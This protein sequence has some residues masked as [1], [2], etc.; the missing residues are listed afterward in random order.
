VKYGSNVQFQLSERAT[1]VG[2]VALKTTGRQVGKTCK[3]QTTSN[4]RKK[5]CTL[6]VGKGSF[7]QTAA[8]GF[9]KVPFT[10]KVSGHNLKLGSYRVQLLAT[11]PSGN[12]SAIVTKNFTIRK[13]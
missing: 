13:P 8:G 6:W 3:K 7:K 11:D 12:K 1:V 2:S 9:L 4:K 5:K 10:G